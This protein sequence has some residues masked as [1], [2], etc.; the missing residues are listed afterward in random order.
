MSLIFILT[1][2]ALIAAIVERPKK[3]KAYRKR[4]GR[5][6]ELVK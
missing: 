3:V 6:F 2:A 5:S 4:S 1:P